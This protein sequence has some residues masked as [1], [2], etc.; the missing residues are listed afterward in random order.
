[1]TAPFPIFDG[2]NDL[3]LRLY[4]KDP[5]QAVR[6]F[7]EGDGPGFMQEKVSRPRALP[8]GDLVLDLGDGR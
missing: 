2:H 3:L 6:T 8:R 7:L 4:R 1:M 5:A